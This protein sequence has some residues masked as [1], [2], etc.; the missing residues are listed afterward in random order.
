MKLSACARLYNSSGENMKLIKHLFLTLLL[1]PVCVLANN[2]PPTP[3]LLAAMQ[4]QMMEMQRQMMAMQGQLAAERKQREELQ[5]EIV[6]LRTARQPSR[7][8]HE[9]KKAGP[10]RVESTSSAPLTPS[11]FAEQKSIEGRSESYAIGA[12]VVNQP[13]EPAKQVTIEPKEEKRPEVEKKSALLLSI[14]NYNDSPAYDITALA[15]LPGMP[16]EAAE[17]FL[18]IEKT[19]PAFWQKQDC[20]ATFLKHTLMRAAVLGANGLVKFL[21]AHDPKGVE[22]TKSLFSTVVNHNAAIN[23]R[24]LASYITKD[25]NADC[26]PRTW[27]SSDAHLLLPFLVETPHAYSCEAFVLN[28]TALSLAALAGHENVVETLLNTLL[29][30]LMD[31]NEESIDQICHIILNAFTALNQSHNIGKAPVVVKKAGE[32]LLKNLG[33]PFVPKY[34]NYPAI[35]KQLFVAYMKA[36]E[37]FESTYA[38]ID[39]IRNPFMSG[40]LLASSEGLQIM[41]EFYANKRFIV[42]TPPGSQAIFEGMGRVFN[43]GEKLGKLL[44]MNSSP[45][46]TVYQLSRGMLAYATRNPKLLAR[47]KAY[48]RTQ[49]ATSQLVANQLN[50]HMS[51]ISDLSNIVSCYAEPT[52]PAD[53]ARQI[54]AME[55]LTE[56]RNFI[57]QELHQRLNNAEIAPE[58]EPAEQGL[59]QHLQNMEQNN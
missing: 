41:A 39:N 38:R 7:D 35:L 37:P 54:L 26:I 57:G 9:E 31:K 55:P 46:S 42:P 23:A 22:V 25:A 15:G 50:E 1:M 8:E 24:A 13:S 18:A 28:Q 12:P 33:L 40:M 29:E 32:L 56:D 45:D 36:L 14:E 30:G 43:N 52:I 48:V 6:T 5:T 19:L 11:V 34:E 59:L 27:E 10:L 44:S 47:L 16:P 53:L 2:N 21:V 17:E 49:Q 20:V 3:D 58:A 51:G 4:Q